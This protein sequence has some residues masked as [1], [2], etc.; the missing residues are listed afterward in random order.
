MSVA[1]LTRMGQTVRVGNVSYYLPALP[2]SIIENTNILNPKSCRSSDDLVPLTVIDDTSKN[3]SIVEFESS[4]S[5][6]LR[7]DDVFQIDFL[8]SKH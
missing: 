8:Q 4:V 1:S 5:K 6:F 7:S 2:V 3:R